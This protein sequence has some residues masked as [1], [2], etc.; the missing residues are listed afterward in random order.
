M[1]L[2]ERRLKVATEEE[3]KEFGPALKL[4]YM[5]EDEDTAGGDGWRHLQLTWRTNEVT[6]VFRTLD[7]RANRMK[8]DNLKERTKRT[9]PGVSKKCALKDAPTWAVKPTSRNEI[10]RPACSTRTRGGGIRTCGGG[11][12]RGVETESRS[13]ARRAITYSADDVVNSLTE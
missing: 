13:S 12:G 3:R 7:N 10:P 11:S 6:Q 2:L 9:C 4:E 5:T 8:K 1:Q